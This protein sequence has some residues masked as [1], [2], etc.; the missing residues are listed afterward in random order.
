MASSATQDAGRNGQDVA[1]FLDGLGDDEQFCVRLTDVPEEWDRDWASVPNK[2]MG[3]P[4]WPP[5]N[6]DDPRRCELLKKH[7][8]DPHSGYFWFEK[9]I[10]DDGTLV[11]IGDATKVFMVLTFLDNWGVPGWPP[12][13][14][15]AKFAGCSTVD[16]QRHTGHLFELG[17]I[18]ERGAE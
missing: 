9:R 14:G 3:R 18:H 15:V 13:D 10:V 2:I 17:L 6:V 5:M 1:S 11:K 16:V 4:G 7:K 8:W 12:D